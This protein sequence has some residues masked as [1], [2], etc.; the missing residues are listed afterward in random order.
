MD[1]VILAALLV[2]VSTACSTGPMQSSG[3][4]AANCAAERSTWNSANMPAIDPCTGRLT[5][6]HGG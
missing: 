1:K 4:S 6:Y 3:N 5:L 2:L